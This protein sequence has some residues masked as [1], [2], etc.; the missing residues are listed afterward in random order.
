MNEDRA[1]TRYIRAGAA[2]YVM[3]ALG[4]LISLGTWS[5]IAYF[6]GT[7]REI[8]AYFVATAAYFSSAKLMQTGAAGSVVMPMYMQAIEDGGADAGWRMASNI[9]NVTTLFAISMTVVVIIAAPLVVPWM[10]P[11]F[12]AD[13]STTV[14][15]LL[16][17]MALAFVALPVTALITS[18]LLANEKYKQPAIYEF[19]GS[20]A[21]LG[22]ILIGVPWLGVNAIAIG[23]VL[24]AFISLVLLYRSLHGLGYRHRWRVDLKDIDMREWLKRMRPYLGY[25]VFL[26]AQTYVLMALLS[27]LPPGT[28]A[29][30]RYASD[31]VS[32][33]VGFVSAPVGA[34]VLPALSRQTV[35]D[36][37]DEFRKILAR[38][39][40]Y[41]VLISLPIFLV[42]ALDSRDF[43]ELLMHRGQFSSDDAGAVALAITIMAGNILASPVHSVLQKAFV[44]FG[45]TGLLNVVGILAQVY[46]ILLMFLLI[47]RWGYIGAAWHS[48]AAT[49]A[50]V[51]TGAIILAAIGLFPHMPT[52][53]RGSGRV[54][55]VVAAAASTGW[56]VTNLWDA[57][58]W[59]QLGLVALSVSLV[60]V[61]VGRALRLEEVIIALEEALRSLKA[62]RA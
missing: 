58:A 2:I 41:S 12:D 8:E 60:G 28:M 34:I 61:A 13:S 37:K 15:G 19:I 16:R 1:A 31:L 25:L 48:L 54:A 22:A 26:Q 17:I 23:L 38:S 53:V 30:Y 44:A 33:V 51:I 49:V 46:T 14:V 4:I 7:G 42:L 24:S 59:L 62:R 27:L 18:L 11:G 40:R 3:R 39:A 47:P 29:I 20:V 45:R 5:S 57:W 43:V 32:R 10:I 36:D 50:I 6:F 21:Y 55:I 56:A 52:L 9:I 35:L